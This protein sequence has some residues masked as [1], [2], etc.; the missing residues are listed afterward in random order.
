MLVTVTVPF[1]LRPTTSEPLAVPIVFSV[2]VLTVLF[3]V[4]RVAVVFVVAT[5][6]PVRT[7]AAFGFAAAVGDGVAAEVTVGVSTALLL[8]KTGAAAD[9]ADVTGVTATVFAAMVGV[10]VVA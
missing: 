2:D 8:L 9:V 10:S 7:F 3:A 6:A 1:A 4:V 5:V